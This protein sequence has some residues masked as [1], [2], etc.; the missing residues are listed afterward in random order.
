MSWSGPVLDFRLTAEEVILE[1]QCL[2]STLPQLKNYC[3]DDE[4]NPSFLFSHIENAEILKVRQYFYNNNLLWSFFDY[5]PPFAISLLYYKCF[6]LN[7]FAMFNFW[8][9]GEYRTKHYVMWLTRRHCSPKWH[10]RIRRSS[11]LNLM[12]TTGIWQVLSLLRII[13]D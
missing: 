8:I 11:I 2:S 3:S 7:I 12:Y 4:K 6:Y 1:K 5:L 9:V 13:L 10:I